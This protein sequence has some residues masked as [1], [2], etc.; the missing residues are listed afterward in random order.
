M[1]GR[2]RGCGRVRERGHAYMSVCVFGMCARERG[3]IVVSIVFGG[4]EVC[5]AYTSVLVNLWD[6]KHVLGY[7]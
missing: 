1:H 5:I 2:G 3:V 6:Q 4:G 7:L